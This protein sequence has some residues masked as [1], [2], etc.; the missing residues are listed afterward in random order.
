[1]TRRATGACRWHRSAS[2]RDAASAGAYGARLRSS[3]SSVKA[4]G[5][6]RQRLQLARLDGDHVDLRGSPIVQPNSRH[7]PVSTV[8]AAGDCAASGTLNWISSCTASSSA[9]TAL[10]ASSATRRDCATRWR[11]ACAARRSRVRRSRARRLHLPRPARASAVMPRQ[12]LLFMS[13][14]AR[15]RSSPLSAR[16]RCRRARRGRHA[17]QRVVG[18]GRC[19]RLWSRR[20]ARLVASLRFLLVGREVHQRHAEQGIGLGRGGRRRSR[21]RGSAVAGGAENGGGWQA[22]GFSRRLR[23]SSAAEPSR[24]AWL[25]L[26]ARRRRRPAAVGCRF[27]IDRRSRF[28]V[29]LKISLQ[30]PQRTRPPRSLSWSGATRKVVRQWGQRVASAMARYRAPRPV[31][32]GR[33]S[34][35]QPSR[36]A[37]RASAMWG[38]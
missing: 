29:P 33:A 4:V 17:R 6:A 9:R 37:R 13:S 8:A 1:M 24:A 2:V 34:A 12:G 23:R 21:S 3:A 7:R 26:A 35:T 15:A 11:L 36:S 10:P 22:H 30:A 25:P 19:I 38:A 20:R 31:A 5:A 18:A 27:R 28:S 32:P 14:I 16:R